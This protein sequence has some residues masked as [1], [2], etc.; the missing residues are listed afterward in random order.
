[1]YC[2]RGLAFVEPKPLA[3]IGNYKNILIQNILQRNIRFQ[4]T[5]C[6]CLNMSPMVVVGGSGQWESHNSLPLRGFRGWWGVPGSAW[7]G[8]G[9]GGWHPRIQA[10]TGSITVTPPATHPPAS[11]ILL[12]ATTMQFIQS[13]ASQLSPTK[14]V[15]HLTQAHQTGHIV[16]HWSSGPIRI[17]TQSNTKQRKKCP[18]PETQSQ[19]QNREKQCPETQSNTLFRSGGAIGKIVASYFK[20]HLITCSSPHQTNLHQKYSIAHNAKVTAQKTQTLNA[21][22]PPPFS[23]QSIAKEFKRRGLVQILNGI[24]S[25]RC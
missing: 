14:S 4:T 17:N 15:V 20:I 10:I 1:M 7:A 6:V 5:T 11:I 25:R 22:P 9:V 2:E 8:W 3:F 19:T 24:H 13:P 16:H 18:D 21:S 12:Q 23:L